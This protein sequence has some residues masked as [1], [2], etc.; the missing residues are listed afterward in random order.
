M[1]FNSSQRIGIVALLLLIICIVLLP[2][3]LSK[4]E[5]DLFLLRETESIETDSLITSNDSSY[6][7]KPVYKTTT[8]PKKTIP[9]VE[10]NS[11]DSAAL[12]AIPGIGGYYA[13]RIIRYRSLLGG[14]TTVGQLKEVK[15]TYF[16]VDSSARYFTVDPALIIKR[17]LDT[18]DFKAILRHPYLEYE[19][20]KLIFNAKRKFKTISFSLL[21]TNQVLT[22]D[23]LKKIKPYFQ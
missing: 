4:K 10:L 9:K 8:R 14:Y 22:A 5:P 3:Q 16:N 13:S 21:E 20:V 6:N 15:M 7:A 12:D 1:I 2:R 11:A 23:K 17:N 19:D 18:M